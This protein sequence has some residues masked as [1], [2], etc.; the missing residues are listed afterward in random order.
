MQILRETNSHVL[1][2]GTLQAEGLYNVWNKN[3]NEISV[4]FDEQEL[5]ESSLL[6]STDEEFDAI[7]QS[8]IE[9]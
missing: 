6:H 3:T 7:C 4:W 2:K 5:N 1:N 8:Y 9:D